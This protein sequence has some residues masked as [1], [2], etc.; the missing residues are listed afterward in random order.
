[1][2]KEE[3]TL[4]DLINLD[5]SSVLNVEELMDVTGGSAWDELPHYDCVFFFNY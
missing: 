2:E 3:K 5:E 4:Q 1:M